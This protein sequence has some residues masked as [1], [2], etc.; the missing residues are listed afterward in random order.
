MAEPEHINPVT[1]AEASNSPPVDAQP[2][3]I[4]IETADCRIPVAKVMLVNN[5][6]FFSAMFAHGGTR[7]VET[8]VVKLP[9]IKSK[10]VEET[11]KHICDPQSKLPSISTLEGVAQLIELYRF[12]ELYQFVNLKKDILKFLA[13]RIRNSNVW[14]LF[15]IGVHYDYEPITKVAIKY[16][17]SRYSAWRDTVDDLDRITLFNNTLKNISYHAMGTLLT[18]ESNINESYLLSWTCIWVQRNPMTRDDQILALFGRLRLPLIRLDILV[19]H[20]EYLNKYV[21][22]FHAHLSYL[23]KYYSLLHPPACGFPRF[24]SW[25]DSLGGDISSLQTEQFGRLVY[26]SRG[27][28]I[29]SFNLCALEVGFQ[30]VHYNNAIKFELKL[31]FHINFVELQFSTDDYNRYSYMIEYTADGHYWKVLYDYRRFVCANKQL[32]IFDPIVACSFRV[33]GDQQIGLDS[34]TRTKIQT[35]ESFRA[36]FRSNTLLLPVTLRNGLIQEK[37]YATRMPCKLWL[38]C[39]ITGG[40]GV[41]YKGHRLDNQD[42][43]KI[44]VILDQ[45]IILG[46]I[47]FKLYDEDDRS[48]SYQVR[49]FNEDTKEWDVVAD[50]ANEKS[51]QEVWFSMRPVNLLQL[52]GVAISNAIDNADVFLIT[53]FRLA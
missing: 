14:L 4:I 3:L 46:G 20:Q 40:T 35:I 7:E 51:A 16:L 10:V 41:E 5:S 32:L 36:E 9:E 13:E 12:F 38:R 29:K 52:R 23:S 19:V 8:G 43:E 17:E 37:F 1:S 18:S 27:L 2:N 53:N 33:H 24:P 22:D 6:D 44:L 11:I 30:I 15:D 47:T 25:K 42:N 50:R 21:E 31:P 39:G 34:G 26:R 48:Y 28:L 45:P 49:A